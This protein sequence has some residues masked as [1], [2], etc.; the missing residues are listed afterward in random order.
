M[1]IVFFKEKKPVKGFVSLGI[2]LA[3]VIFA[4]W[5]FGGFDSGMSAQDGGLGVFSFN[6]NNFVNPQGWSKIFKDIGLYGN[7]QY[8]GFAYLGAG[9]ILLV[10]LAVYSCLIEIVNVKRVIKDNNVQIIAILLVCILAI[11]VAASPKVTIGEKVLAEFHFPNFV[12]DIWSIFR[13]SGRIVWVAVYLIMFSAILGLLQIGRKNLIC[14]V[15]SLILIL[16]VYDISDVINQK[17]TQFKDRIEYQTLLTTDDF[18]NELANDEEIKH[19]VYCSS[20]DLNT[21]YS[22][23]DWALENEITLNDFYFARSIRELVNE[24][25]EQILKDLPADTVYIF[26]ENDKMMCAQYDLHYYNIDGLIVG[27]VNTINGFSE[28]NNQEFSQN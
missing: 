9:I 14:I 27:C 10:F 28:M 26:S 19:V 18:W 21:M 24:N 15:L 17:Y 3:S 5:L 4:A 25:R 12:T 7:G 20:M 1:I 11:A 13:S 22:I 8:E 2:Y 6:L 16:Q 23:T